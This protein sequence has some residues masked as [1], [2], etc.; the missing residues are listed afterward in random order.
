MTTFHSNIR[1]KC[2]LYNRVEQ[3]NNNV[4]IALQLL[5]HLILT[6]I[7]KVATNIIFLL[8]IRKPKFKE[9]IEPTVMA[10]QNSNHC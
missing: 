10:F 5:S 8:Q 6:N 2:R 4:V 9:V 7:L 3:A 1:N